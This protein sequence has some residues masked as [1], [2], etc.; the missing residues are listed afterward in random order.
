MN[1]LESTLKNTNRLINVKLNNGEVKR[2]NE[3]DAYM[4]VKDGKASY[5]SKTEY[6]KFIGTFEKKEEVTEV[7]ENEPKTKRGKNSK[8]E[9]NDK[10]S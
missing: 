3:Y 10:K 6:K 5:T 2:I 4:I 1:K 8:K 7:I 9:T